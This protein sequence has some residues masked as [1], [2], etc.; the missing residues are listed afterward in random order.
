MQSMF[1][2]FARLVVAEDKRATKILDELAIRRAQQELEK[3]L[4]KDIINKGS[5]N[6]L[7][8]N[9]LYNIIN[10]TEGRK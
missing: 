3:P 8:H 5:I 9:T 2:E 6:E 7:D 1:D 4:R 10:G